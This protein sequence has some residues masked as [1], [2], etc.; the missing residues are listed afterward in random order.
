MPLAEEV[1]ALIRDLVPLILDDI[2]FF[3]KHIP[4]FS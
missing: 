4:S 3:A 2:A 1:V